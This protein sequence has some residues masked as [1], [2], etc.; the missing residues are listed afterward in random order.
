MS[1]LGLVPDRQEHVPPGWSENPSAWRT[2][3][4]VAV[5]AALG[6]LVAG[7]L[8]LVE[9]GVVSSAWD[10]VFDHGSDEVLHSAFSRSL[11]VPDA[12]LGAAAYTVEF[13]LA[14]IGPVDRWRRMPWAALLFDGLVAATAAGGLALVVVQATVVH[15]FCLLC[16]SSAAVSVTVL[17]VSRLREGRAAWQY[18]RSQRA[19]GCSW[20]SALLGPDQGLRPRA[21]VWV[22]TARAGTAATLTVV[23]GLALL[24]LAVGYYTPTGASED[25]VGRDVVLGTLL[26]VF[27]IAGVLAPLHA[28]RACLG[29]GL[30][31][32]LLVATALL[33]TPD[34][35]SLVPAAELVVGGL[36]LAC[37][38]TEGL[39]TA[40][41]AHLSS[42]GS[43][44]S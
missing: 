24:V 8:T 20:T 23:G 15:A 10:P 4:V 33:A 36:T 6:A 14:W 43:H 29:V 32:A 19:R 18:V 9:V 37:A 16:L 41:A 42:P 22:A 26:V 35:L 11:P 39:C 44:A 34:G 28:P 5:L 21:G 17:A 7:Y 1:G 2:R 27:G 38:V 31:G 3:A 12:A 25:L 30:V 40:W 13:V